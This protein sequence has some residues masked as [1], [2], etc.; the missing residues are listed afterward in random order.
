MLKYVVKDESVYNTTWVGFSSRLTLKLRYLY[1]K[2]YIGFSP[3][4]TDESIQLPTCRHIM[5][6][7]WDQMRLTDSTGPVDT[8]SFQRS[9]SA[10]ASEMV[11]GTYA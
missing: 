10:G 5:P 1:S 3:V 6:S 11:L 7:L 8:L 4:D 2:V 9:G